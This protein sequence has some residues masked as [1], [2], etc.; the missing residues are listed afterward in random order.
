M[1]AYDWSSFLLRI[2]IDADRQTI[3]NSWLS[4]EGLE[5]WFLR[6]AVFTDSSGN[7]RQRNEKISAGDAYSWMWHGWP[8]EVNEQGNI[9]ELNDTYLK[10]SFGKAGNVTVTTKEEAGKTV[11]ELFQDEIPVDETSRS[12]YHI[13]CTKGWVFYLTNLKSLLE[14]GIDMRNRDVDLK[15]VVNS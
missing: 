5:N 1:Q 3:F 13:G 10:F 14:G 8:D 12:Y 4:Q 9:L 15:E 11:L 2:P 6:S 7:K